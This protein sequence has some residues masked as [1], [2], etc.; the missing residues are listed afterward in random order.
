MEP[1]KVGVLGKLAAL[2]S[3]GMEQ[4][5]KHMAHPHKVLVVM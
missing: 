1:L 4:P 3:K 2:L 5:V